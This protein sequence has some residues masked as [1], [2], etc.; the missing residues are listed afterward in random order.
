[1]RKSKSDK[2][3][4][5][6]NKTI[7]NK[8][9]VREVQ[10]QNPLIAD[11]GGS[12]WYD[13]INRRS[14]KPK[15]ENIIEPDVKVSVIQTQNNNN[16]TNE[17]KYENTPID[18]NLKMI[19]TISSQGSNLSKIWQKD[20]QNTSDPVL[21]KINDFLKIL[22][23]FKITKKPIEETTDMLTLKHN[24]STSK[25]TKYKFKNTKKP[26]NKTNPR[27]K[28]AKKDKKIKPKLNLHAKSKA[29]NATNKTFERNAT[30]LL[31][32]PTLEVIEKTKP[33]NLGK[34]ELVTIIINDS[35]DFDKVNSQTDIPLINIT[36][37]A[38]NKETN[39]DVVNLKNATILYNGLDKHV[40]SEAS[41]D[42]YPTILILND[43][44][45]K[46]DKYRSLLLSIIDHETN[47]LNNEWLK[48]AIENHATAN[49][50]TEENK[51]QVFKHFKRMGR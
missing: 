28:T 3:V 2:N 40:P 5:K 15:V 20:A 35:S 11:T 42:T 19:S 43:Y 16:G 50:V 24:N 38:V 1:M 22:D 7:N 37:G 27:N 48:Y 8:R 44:S 12:F 46:P 14:I 21:N 26:Q 6:K 25:A 17:N 39:I 34:S 33:N 23:N 4:A 13:Y 10:I 51:R 36:N 30:T 45:E 31:M 32:N 47:K 49:D 9:E 18:Q 29:K 41:T